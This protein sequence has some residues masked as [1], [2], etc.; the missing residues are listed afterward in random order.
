MSGLIAHFIGETL[1]FIC[2]VAFAAGCGLVIAWVL[3]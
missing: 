2:G 3:S 1:A